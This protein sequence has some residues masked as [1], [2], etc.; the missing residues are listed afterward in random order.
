MLRTYRLSLFLGALLG[1]L[2]VAILFVF[3]YRPGR[4]IP[5]I[6]FLVVLALCLVCLAPASA[7]T[8]FSDVG[9]PFQLFTG[10]YTR[11]DRM[12]GSFVLSS[13]SILRA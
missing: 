13:S 8:F 2:G 4:I 10:E 11:I 1:L 7:D 9:S 5:M 6:R 12:S 3:A